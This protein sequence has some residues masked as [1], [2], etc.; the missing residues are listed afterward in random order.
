MDKPVQFV[1]APNG[2]MGIIG[3]HSAMD[4]TPTT[5]MCDE[6]LDAVYSPN[7]DHGP[8][9][10]GSIKPVALDFDTT[11]DIEAR[12]KVAKERSDELVSSQAMTYH[13]TPYGKKEIK[14]Y[15]IGPDGWTQMAIQ[16]AYDRWCIKQGKP[17]GSRE[18]G[19][20]Y[21]AA[22]TRRFLKGR[23]EAIRV[24]SNEVRA[25]LT[26]M[27]EN[28]GASNDD[29]RALLQVAT[30]RHIGDAKDAGNGVGIDR[31][32]LGLRMLL[33]EEDDGE[34]SSNTQW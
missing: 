15:S 24:V 28:S 13:L 25:W 5:R 26:A 20:T 8:H 17:L 4:G 19:A 34:L 18:T 33:K 30:K 32:L 31:H 23:T 2:E 1:L 3:E 7:F 21:E 14:G 11:V 22:T 9:N 16:L 29:K 6:V 27:R 12:I 10:S